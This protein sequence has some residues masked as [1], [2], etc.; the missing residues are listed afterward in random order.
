MYRS[1]PYLR[2]AKE[3][4]ET[5]NTEKQDLCNF[6]FIYED[7]TTELYPNHGCFGQVRVN[8]GLNQEFDYASGA[9]RTPKQNKKRGAIKYFFNNSRI[10]RAL[11]KNFGRLTMGQL[12]KY[13]K[14]LIK[15]SSFA[16][17]YRSKN[18]QSV[19]ENGAIFRT[20]RSAQQVM[21]AATSLRNAY[22]WPQIPFFWNK[23]SKHI[24]PHLALLLAYSAIC[25]DEEHFSF[26]S[27]WGGEHQRFSS[28]FFT[29]SAIKNLISG[30]VIRENTLPMSKDTCL[31]GIEKMWTEPHDWRVPLKAGSRKTLKTDRWGHI[32]IVT[33]YLFDDLKEELKK[34]EEELLQD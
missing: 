8:K 18:V 30:T 29:K 21:G 24:D 6:G 34:I 9:K 32:S 16:E 10:E 11:E 28:T 17:N 23:F 5:L 2:L 27:S 20:G 3:G 33:S 26:R 22:E 1:K 14:W 19:I 31:A 15:D 13:V 4:L 12:K 25:I 7:G